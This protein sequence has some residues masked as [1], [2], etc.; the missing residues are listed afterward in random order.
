M[1]IV[2]LSSDQSNQRALAQKLARVCEVSAIV[3]SQN[4]PK[5]RKSRQEAARI[6]L[7]KVEVR[8]FGRPYVNAWNR[9]RARYAKA[10]PS[11]PTDRIVRVANVN[12]A[13]SVR[14]IEEHAPDY[15]L[16]SGTNLVGPAIVKAA[17]KRGGILNLHTGISPYVKGGPNCTNWCLAESLF[18][19]I[20][21]TVMWLDLGI[22]TGQIVAT[23]RTAVDGTESLDDLHWKV[24]EHAHDVYVRVAKALADGKA[25][26]RMPQSAIS[27]GR[28][29]YMREWSATAMV[30]GRLNFRRWSPRLLSSP[31]MLR[32]VSALRLYPAPR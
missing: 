24:M 3:L 26:P 6:L 10:Y 14:L 22:D 30:K 17:S 8:I 7:N 29:F 23:E 28:T 20:G 12:D 5:K 21:N 11:W 1:K 2:F 16:V 4:I 31:A 25:V 9:M 15:V 18:H 13:A 32:D 27:E 19:L